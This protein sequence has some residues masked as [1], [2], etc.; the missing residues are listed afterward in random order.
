MINTTTFFKNL[1]NGENGMISAED[2]ENRIKNNE[3]V[4]LMDIRKKEDFEE[5]HIKN[6]IN[7]HWY[8]VGDLLTTNEIP[9]DKDVI[10]ICYTGQSSSQIATV[11]NLSG[12]KAYSLMDGIIKWIEEGRKVATQ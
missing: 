8:E 6:S 3:D 1:R 4:F 2:L 10:V 5:V 7:S 11:L 12:Y 9:K